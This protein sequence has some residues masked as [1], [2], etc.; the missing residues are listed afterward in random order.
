MAEAIEN[1]VRKLIIDETPVN[2]KY[3]ERMS[4]LL[5]ALILERKTQALHYTAYLEKVVALARKILKP[6][7]TTTYPP[8]I[9][10]GALRAF[11]DNLDQDEELAVRLDMEIRRIKKA[12]FRG[13]RFKEREIRIAIKSVL[14]ND[15]GLVDRV[16]AIV[17]KQREY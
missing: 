1:N 12:D 10:T 2:P 4:H 8:A 7:S 11:Y 5:A 16:F 6:E 15:P 14:G 17:E 3:F 13:N 9:N